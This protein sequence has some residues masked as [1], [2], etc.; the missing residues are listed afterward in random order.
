MANANANAT[1]PCEQST[2]EE[3]KGNL[4]TQS[5]SGGRVLS[6]LMFPFFM[7]RPPSGFGVLTTTGRRTGKKRRKCVRVIRRGEEVY[8]VMLGP[9]LVRKGNSA[10]ERKARSGV[11]AGWLWNIRANPRVSLRIRGGTFAGTARELEAAE[12]E[13]ARDV[14]CGSVN[15]FDYLECYFHLGGPPTCARIEK[16]HR[17]WFENGVPLVIELAS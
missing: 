12:Q 14:F 15:A 7:V 5:S 13:R 11:V 10:A 17:H 9:A 3:R 16:L 2:P 1:P 6:A 4:F 8:L